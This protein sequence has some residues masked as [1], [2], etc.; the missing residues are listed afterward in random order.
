VQ[1]ITV[2]V[3]DER[4]LMSLELDSLGRETE[5]DYRAGGIKENS[6]SRL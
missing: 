5:I 4:R 2:V 6:K 3:G 1:S